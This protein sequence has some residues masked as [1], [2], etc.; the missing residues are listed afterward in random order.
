MDGLPF[1]VKEY[2]ISSIDSPRDL[3]SFALTRKEWKSIIVPYHLEYR[4]LKIRPGRTAIW[5]HLADRRDLAKNIRSIYL[6]SPREP[7]GEIYPTTLLDNIDEERHL[8]NDIV[9]DPQYIPEMLRALRNVSC[10]QELT[11][12]DFLG[13]SMLN[14][15]F[16]ALGPCPA[17]LNL[18][19]GEVSPLMYQLK[20]DNVSVGQIG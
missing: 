18:R 11:W 9:N 3:L 10:L 13:H 12:T 2:F 17:L 15:L 6:I 4:K 16:E 20:P 5:R 14:D 1:D 7:T 19:L 8:A